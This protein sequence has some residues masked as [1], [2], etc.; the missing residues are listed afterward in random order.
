VGKTKIFFVNEKA[1]SDKSLTTILKNINCRIN[2]S[3]VII[4]EAIDKAKLSNTDLII[5]NVK[6]K[7]KNQLIK[8]LNKLHSQSGL[9]VI[10]LTD[11]F[12]EK[13]LAS[14]ESKHLFGW[15]TTPYNQRELKL[16]IEITLNKARINNFETN[17]NLLLKAARKINQIVNTADNGKK[18]ANDICKTF[19]TTAGFNTAFIAFTDKSNKIV[20][21]TQSGI[22]NFH[23]IKSSLNGQKYPMWIKKTLSG[24]EILEI[25]NSGQIKH[26]L[27]KPGRISLNI[28]LESSGRIFGLISVVLKKREILSEEKSLLKSIASDIAFSLYNIEIKN[29]N[30]II[31]E[32]LAG[33]EAKYRMVIENAADIIFTTNE[34]GNFTFVNI[35][36]LLNTGYSADELLKSNYMDLILPE[37][38]DSVRNFYK[39]QSESKQTSAYIEYPFYTKEGKIKW[40][41]QNSTLILENNIFK[42]FHCI[43]RDITERKEIEF[44]L[45]ESEK[46][47]WL[48]VESSPNAIIVHQNGKIVFVNDSCVKL[49]GIKSKS[50]LINKQIMDFIHSDSQVLAKKSTYKNGAIGSSMFFEE[51]KL[52]RPDKKILEVEIARS[53][54][55]FNNKKCTQIVINDIS[56]RKRIE[57]ELRKHQSEVTTLIDNLP[58]FAFLKDVNGKY[59]VANQKFCN[60]M[61][62]TKEQ[63]IGNTDYKFMRREKADNYF[64]QDVKVLKTGKMLSFY[65]ED[66]LIDNKYLTIGTRKVPIKDD[67]GNVFGLIGLG[68]DVTEQKE[69]EEAIKRYTKELEDLNANKDKFFSIISHDLRSPFQGLL[70]LSNALDEEYENLR[71]E[72]IRMFISSINSSAKNL[73]NLIDNLL[74]W[75]R[76]QK[77]NIEMNLKPVD[78]HDEIEYNISLLQNNAD[79]KHIEIINKTEEGIFVYSDINIFDST[80]QNLISNAIKFT[81][82]NGKVVVSSTK[83]KLSVDLIVKDNGVGISKEN[84]EKLFRIDKKLSTPGTEMEPG[85]GLGLLICKELIEMQGGTIKVRSKLNAGTEFTV[86]F[87]LYSEEI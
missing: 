11:S 47:Y 8:P 80:I 1:D 62:V 74:Q 42:G 20:Y 54:V 28:R 27:V 21:T 32:N 75:S 86:S 48:L 43:S 45:Q 7:N 19:V 70:G 2:N 9:P 63:L 40:Y 16:T 5:W 17:F 53:S 58:G 44:A 36:G 13:I 39:K 81:K 73:Y 77:S 50:E 79:N 60:A 72:E 46:K 24:Q 25:K 12:D 51:F 35:A 64:A 67:N 14:I 38:K 83:K 76:A 41:G 22:T 37:Y 31:E 69:V 29:K 66:L 23:P 52:L 82:P 33:S 26:P 57:K 84:L 78:L 18:L 87:Q 59:I 56:E 4:N 34:F 61:G 68:I 85:T 6:H 15:L 3:A 30:K 65:E 55:I 71:H 49:A 10:L